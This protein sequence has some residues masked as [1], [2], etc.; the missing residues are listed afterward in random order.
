MHLGVAAAL[1]DGEIVPGDVDVDDGRI[2]TVG[3]YPTSGT[4]LAVPGF[5]DVQVNGFAGVD[6]AT[7]D[8]EGYVAAAAAMA[9]T[10]VT[11]FQP[12]LVSLPE[13]D[14]RAALGV[15]AEARQ[16]LGRRLHGAHLEGPFLSPLRCGA[17]DPAN[18]RDPD[19]ELAGRLLA[20]GPVSHVTLAPELP[21][22]FEL[23][24]FLTGRGV[25]VAVGHSDAGAAVA[26]AAFDAGARA[27]TH[28]FNALRPWS[29]RD[30][31]PAGVALVRDD[32]FVTL[33]ADGIHLAPEA[34]LLAARCS[35][36]RLVAITDAVSAAAALGGGH[37]L[38]D[39]TVRVQDG[40]V[41]LADGTLAGSAL[42]MD[43]A[44]RNLIDLGLDLVS[45]LQAATAAPAALIGRPEL[46]TL[47]P[48]TP[49][50][51]TILDPRLGVTRTLI[52]GRV[53][54]PT[55]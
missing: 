52:G 23:I 47:S 25:T 54:H 13:P 38:A 37:H 21:G 40:A 10:G 36:P 35:G 8:V 51:I 22:A 26:H 50:D 29:H 2:T 46:G 14:L 43:A 15:L 24:G 19:L 17:H 9:A 44:V 39:R 53:V 12:T 34:V 6:F 41:R 4:G 18:L 7:A 3:V 16:V 33:I 1:V 11:C 31:G 45:S 49:A 55:P 20:A 32:V 28:L 42:T 30:P 48:G 5:I 27:V